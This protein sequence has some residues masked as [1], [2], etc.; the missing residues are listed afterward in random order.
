[1]KTY[2]QDELTKILAEHQKWLKN[3]NDGQ[4]ADLRGADLQGAYLQGADLRGAYLQG[5]DLQRANLQGAEG[6]E[7]VQF[8]PETGAF[9][10][11]KK[12]RNDVE[13]SP[14]VIVHLLIPAKAKRSHGTERKCRASFVKTLG[15][16]GGD[17]GVSSYNSDIIYAAGVTTKC[18]EWDENRWNTCGGGIH[19][20]LT[21]AEAEAY[22]L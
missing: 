16:I 11:W 6:L 10:A 9:E 5:A 20:F 13:D 14:D 4:G 17:I 21:R 18:H 22:T 1:M 3:P 2:T 7:Q 8:I 19:F 12:C 15:V